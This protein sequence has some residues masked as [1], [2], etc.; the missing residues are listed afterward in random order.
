VV[1]MPSLWRESFG[2]VAAE[3]MINGIPVL[4]TSRGA[5][6]EVVGRA[7]FLFDVPERY[8]PENRT[9]P[10]AEEVAPWV[11]TIIRLWDDGVYYEEASE[12]CRERAKRWRP[13]VLL[14][15]YERVL[16]PAPTVNP[17]S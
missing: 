4:G 9:V 2:R 17:N 5:L 15:R 12:R 14:P 13:E 16:E 1:L 11:E 6:P 3:A 10:S 8:T 7:G